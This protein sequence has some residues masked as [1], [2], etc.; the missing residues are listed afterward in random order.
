MISASPQIV[1]RQVCAT[2][3]TGCIKVNHS[4]SKNRCL[5]I[6]SAR[7]PTDCS[8]SVKKDDFHREL[9]YLVP[10]WA[11]MSV[12]APS[13]HWELTTGVPPI[14]PVPTFLVMWRHTVNCLLS[15]SQPHVRQA[16]PL[17]TFIFSFSMNFLFIY[18]LKTTGSSGVEMLFD[19]CLLFWSIL[20]WLCWV[21]MQLRCS[22]RL[23]VLMRMQACR[24]FYF[25]IKIWIAYGRLL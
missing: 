20:V 6:I 11:I 3:R 14:V 9:S 17:S 5:F 24:G 13:W 22:T 1:D 25:T 15:S 18:V 7:A 4:Y 10:T 16:C 21:M 2:R 19:T 12:I 8:L 23:A